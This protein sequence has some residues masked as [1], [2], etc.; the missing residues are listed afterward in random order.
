MVKLSA[1]YH[2]QLV[3]PMDRAMWLIDFVIKHKGAP[4]LKINPQGLNFIQYFC[5]DTII[6]LILLLSF[7]FYILYRF[8][9]SILSFLLRN[10]VKPFKSKID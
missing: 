1:V 9:Y 7:I 2:D 8:I 10:L 6:F 3:S 4:H 5:L